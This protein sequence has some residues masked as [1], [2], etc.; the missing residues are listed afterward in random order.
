MYRKILVPTDG[1]S[2]SKAAVLAAIQ[3]A[4]HLGST[5]LALHVRVPYTPPAFAEI[6][7]IPP[8][9]DE[10]FEDSLKNASEHMLAAIAVDAQAKGVSCSTLSV[11]SEHVWETI[12][13]VS[14]E[15][16]C[17]LIVMSTHGRRGLAALIIGSE[18]NEV[19]THSHVPVLLYR[20]LG[21]D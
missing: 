13:H 9:S 17:D 10:D 16:D 11:S 14:K 15:E 2:G 7:A 18:A 3:L 4:Q 8:M 1:S 20:Q 21:E 6:P 5:M 19:V 12:L